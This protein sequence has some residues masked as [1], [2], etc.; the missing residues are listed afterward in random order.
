[1]PESQSDAQELEE[2][3]AD[4][5]VN[6]LDQVTDLLSGK[7]EKEETTDE[8]VAP[9][10]EQDAEPETEDSGIDYGMKIPMPGDGETLTLGELKDAYQEKQ[11]KELDLT[12]RENKLSIEY[13]KVKDLVQIADNLAP[14]QR[15][16]LVYHAQREFEQEQA[17]LAH[18]LPELA[19]PEGVKTV[20]NEL[21]ELGAE[22]G[23]SND[24][25]DQVK[26]AVTIKMMHDF[27]KLR[28]S[29][30]EAKETVKPLKSV[31]VKAGKG[32]T[33]VSN[34]DAAINKA[35]KTGSHQDE[36]AAINALISGVK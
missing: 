2:L 16:R 13:D 33:N 19:T 10:K 15:E 36:T 23:V 20:R 34:I 8:E 5:N 26:D 12:D 27:A 21:Y 22:Y 25:V 24:Q 14:E 6:E 35:K 29:V 30:K 18:I 4:P 9:E 7:P 11:T 31:N 1:M 3:L 28:K 17:K 32:R